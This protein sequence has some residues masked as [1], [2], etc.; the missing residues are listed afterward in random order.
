MAQ[1]LLV[2]YLLHDDYYYYLKHTI[3]Q[4][5]IQTSIHPSTYLKVSSNH[6]LKT[7]EI[8]IWESIYYHYIEVYQ[9]EEQVSVCGRGL[10]VCVRLCWT[11]KWRIHSHVLL[12]RKK[13][14]CVFGRLFTP[15]KFSFRSDWQA[16][17]VFAFETRTTCCAVLYRRHDE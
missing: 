5:Y 9:E 7:K 4:T 1:L 10:R 17:C 8:F 3:K 6:P 15:A 2:L 16:Q 13:Y 12:L 14:L 11:E